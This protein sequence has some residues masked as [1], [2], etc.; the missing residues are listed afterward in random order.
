MW[1]MCASGLPLISPGRILWVDCIRAQSSQELDRARWR[2][3][4]DVHR[5][6]RNL[7]WLQEFRPY[8]QSVGGVS[9]KRRSPDPSSGT[10]SPTLLT[11][12]CCNSYCRLPDS[13]DPWALLCISSWGF[14]FRVNVRWRRWRCR[15]QI[16]GNGLD[17]PD[18]T[19]IDKM[20]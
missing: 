4:P 19:W 3:A 14:E 16:R 7:Q 8:I 20:R 13:V 5:S 11:K 1:R 10:D 15:R 6:A 12:L 9:N 2:S 18:G 17:W